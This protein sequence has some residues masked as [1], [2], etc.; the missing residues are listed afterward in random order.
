MSAYNKNYYKEPEDNF[1]EE[2]PRGLKEKPFSAILFIAT[3]TALFFS[4]TLDNT[5]LQVFLSKL[6]YCSLLW[7]LVSLFFYFYDGHK[8]N[9]NAKIAKH[10]MGFPVFAG[11]FA[12]AMA[13]VLAG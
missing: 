7:V 9:S 2:K 5:D 6:A 1:R 10:P 13:I 3:L 8:R 11:L 4:V 12:I